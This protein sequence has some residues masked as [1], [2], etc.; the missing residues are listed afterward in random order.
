LLSQYKLTPREYKNRFDVAVKYTDETYTLFAARLRNLLT[1]YLSSRDVKDFD[2]FRNLVIS[3][4]L[5]ASLPQGPLNYVLSLEGQGWFDPDKVA[6]LADIFVN[7]RGPSGSQK[8]P[9]VRP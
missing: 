5:K 1:Y 9:E 6:S 4:R 3:D 8:A 2:S 7:N